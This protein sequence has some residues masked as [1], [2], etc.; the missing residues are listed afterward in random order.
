VVDGTAA[1][2]SAIEAGKRARPCAE[3]A[4]RQ[5]EKLQARR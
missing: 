1:S 3:A 4:W 2:E 5:V